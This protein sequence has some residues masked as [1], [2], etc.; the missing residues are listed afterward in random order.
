MDFA[1]KFE[2]ALSY[3]DFLDRHASSDQQEQWDNFHQS[4]QLTT[5][6]QELLASFTRQQR[7]LCL[8][9][10]WCGDCVRQCPIFDH[11]Q[12]ASPLLEVR[13]Q[14]RDSDLELQESLRICGGARVPV[15]IFLSEDNLVVGHYGDRTLAKYRQMAAPL[16]GKQTPLGGTELT[17]VV[18]QEWLHEFER[19]Q[20]LLRTSPRLRE[21]HGD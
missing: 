10:T 15:V 7:V 16:D 5:D 20:L 1:D 18:V 19:T 3:R 2:Q 13:Y 6:Q 17:N 8:A 9:G 21:K 12:Q 14:D 4:I 11:F